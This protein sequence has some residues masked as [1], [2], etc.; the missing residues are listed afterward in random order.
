MT[1][2]G[3]QKHYLRGLAHNRKPVVTVGVS[4]VTPAVVEELEQALEHHELLK[5]K[6]PA[7]DRGERQL[8]LEQICRQTGAELVQ[9]LGRNGTVYR[10]AEKPK[11]QL[12]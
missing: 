3:K 4:G 8:L 5:I 12:P 1:L 9:L 6:L 11:V 10:P 2:T 7:S